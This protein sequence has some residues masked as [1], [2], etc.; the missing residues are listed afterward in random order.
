MLTATVRHA[1]RLT[2]LARGKSGHAV[3]MDGA[4]EIG[5]DGSASTPKE[6]LLFALGGCTAF[7]IAT[8]LQKRRLDLRE[9]VVEIEADPVEEHPKV[10]SEARVTYR[11]EGPDLPAADVERAIRLSQDKYCSVGAML[12]RA[13]PIRW[14]AVVN[15]QEIASGVEGV[16]PASLESKANAPSN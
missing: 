16:E 2:F 4:P 3:P 12:R 7:D 8:I 9:F 14:T 1:H 15:G 6:L 11:F 5:G 13:F 10:F